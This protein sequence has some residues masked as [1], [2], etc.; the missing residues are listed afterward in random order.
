MHAEAELRTTTVR[1]TVKRIFEGLQKVLQNL[2]AFSKFFR[3]AAPAFFG[4]KCRVRL[5]F[6]TSRQDAVAAGCGESGPRPIGRWHGWF[7]AL[8]VVSFCSAFVETTQAE[9]IRVVS[10][11]SLQLEKRQFGLEMVLVLRMAQAKDIPPPNSEVSGLLKFKSGI[12]SLSNDRAVSRHASVGESGWRDLGKFRARR[13]PAPDAAPNELE[14][15]AV[16]FNQTD[17]LLQALAAATEAYAPYSRLQLRLDG[18]VQP[19]RRVFGMRRSDPSTPVSLGRW[20]AAFVASPPKNPENEIF[21]SPDLFGTVGESV[22][23]T[24]ALVSLPNNKHR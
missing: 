7:F 23:A 21:K 10:I 8:T 13:S 22:D 12:V 3:L 1:I 18:Q 24:T 5:M 16:G 2:F 20:S 9:P 4:Q 6:K 15:R 14:V 11:R 17:R 19:V